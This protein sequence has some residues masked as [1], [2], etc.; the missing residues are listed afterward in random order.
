[1]KPL[2]ICQFVKLYK[3]AGKRSIWPLKRKV[4]VKCPTFGRE[5]E[6]NDWEGGTRWGWAAGNILLL[7]WGGGTQI[8]TLS[9]ICQALHLK[10]V[11]FYVYVTL[12]FF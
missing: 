11:Y 2:N 1:M 4:K 9:V 10:F 8:C 3:L 7:D 5:Q 6:G 12:T